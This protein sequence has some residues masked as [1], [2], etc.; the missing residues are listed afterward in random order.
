VAALGE[1]RVR[2]G[3]SVLDIGCG[4]GL[5]AVYLASRGVSVIGVDSSA[6]A[7]EI[8]HHR[9]ERAGVQVDWRLGDATRLPLPDGCVD[10][11]LDRGCFHVVPRRR[12]RL[13]IREVARVLRPVGALLLRGA[14]RDDDE[15]GVVGFDRRE[16]ERRFAPHGFSCARFEASTIRARAGDLAAWSALLTR[17]V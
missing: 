3:E 12:R 13:Y 15:A 17:G 9:A 4:A 6:E 5:E 16:I 7:L 14:R 2:R 10:L 8:A 11:A 1:R